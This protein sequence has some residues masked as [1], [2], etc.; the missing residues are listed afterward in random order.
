MRIG[1]LLSTTMI[2][3][4]LV[5]SGARAEQVAE[6]AKAS[7]AGKQN[8]VPGSST[9]HGNAS[10]P[11]GEGVR[12]SG[13]GDR[14]GGPPKTAGGN[15]GAGKPAG[16]LRGHGEKAGTGPGPMNEGRP[17][18]IDTR[19]TVQPRTTKK[20]PLTSE[21]KTGPL[22]VAPHPSPAHQAVPRELSG[23]GRNAIGVRLEDHTSPHAVVP[24]APVQ[25]GSR[26]YGAVNPAIG[27]TGAAK[28]LQGGVNASGGPPPMRSLAV[29]TGT[30]LVQPGSGPGTLGGP[31]KNAAA[32]NGSSIWPKP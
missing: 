5:G 11:A 12:A 26:P 8:A 31:A 29:I 21:K 14:G 6:G 28:P 16:T 1:L 19:M 9:A 18:P 23:S 2:A 7:A 32:I 25:G 4:A 13:S 24:G 17:N 30:G 22:S 10:V 20:A 3:C 27:T 15:A